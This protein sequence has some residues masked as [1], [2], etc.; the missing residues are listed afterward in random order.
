MNI[1]ARIEKRE[2]RIKNILVFYFL[3]LTSYFLLLSGCV[4]EKEVGYKSIGWRV[5]QWAL[6]VINGEERQYSIIEQD[7]CYFWLEVSSKDAVVRVLVREDMEDNYRGLIVKKGDN[8]PI[9]FGYGEFSL[10]STLPLTEKE[11]T[12][13]GRDKVVLPCGGFDCFC[14]RYK[15]GEVWV[16]DKVPIF[17]IVKYTDERTQMILKDYGLKGAKSSIKEETVK[18][19]YV[20]LEKLKT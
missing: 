12:F 6:Y 15:E 19:N 2:L 17:G 7:S 16:S 3:L 1:E 20:N 5:G 14:A 13:T 4:R 18:P 8:K 11:R 9:E 10:V